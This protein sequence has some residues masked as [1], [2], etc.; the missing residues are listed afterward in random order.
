MNH[1]FIQESIDSIGKVK[2]GTLPG[3][4]QVFYYCLKAI[5]YALLAIADALLSIERNNR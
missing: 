5:V 2:E 3:K 4:T 1:R